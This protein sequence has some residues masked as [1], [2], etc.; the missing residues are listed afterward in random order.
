MAKEWRKLE[1]TLRD[2]SEFVA[3]VREAHLR[4]VESVNLNRS[5]FEFHNPEQSLH[6]RALARTGPASEGGEGSEGEEY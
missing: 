4:D 5:R 2:D 3:Q 6:D 1:R